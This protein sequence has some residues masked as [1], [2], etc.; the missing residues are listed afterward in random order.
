MAE[1]RGPCGH[2]VGACGVLSDPI[3]QEMRGISG[4]Q[5]FM[6]P[7]HVDHWRKI[8]AFQEAQLGNPFRGGPKNGK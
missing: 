7:V 6:C 5:D 4:V 8:A 3:P 2:D 1:R